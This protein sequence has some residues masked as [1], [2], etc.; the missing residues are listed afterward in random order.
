[1]WWTLVR[2]QLL[3]RLIGIIQQNT[4]DHSTKWRFMGDWVLSLIPKRGLAAGSSPQVGKWA[5][6]LRIHAHLCPGG[7]ADARRNK[8]LGPSPQ[9]SGSSGNSAFTAVIPHPALRKPDPNSPKM[10]P[11]TFPVPCFDVIAELTQG[12]D[13]RSFRG[14]SHEVMDKRRHCGIVFDQ[15]KVTE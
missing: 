10:L 9:I 5:S 1:M 14:R 2:I 3:R 6:A 8:R 4:R 12:G 7:P 15:H 11:H 13:D